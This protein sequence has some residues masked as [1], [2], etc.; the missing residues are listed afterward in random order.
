M[1]L[2]GKAFT[3]VSI[4][5]ENNYEF[6]EILGDATCNK[7]IVW[8]IQE[9]FPVL[10]NTAGV[11][12]IARLRIN[13]VSKKKFSVLAEKLGFGDF[14]SCEKEIKERRVLETDP[15]RCQKPRV[16]RA[17]L[18]RVSNGRR[19]QGVPAPGS[20]RASAQTGNRPATRGP[21]GAEQPSSRS[22]PPLQLG[23]DGLNAC[24]S[25]KRR[26]VILSSS[27]F[28]FFFF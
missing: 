16:C 19:A 1:A 26:Q 5:T 7:A 20:Y 6:F 3:H 2:Y 13:L 23:T 11:K 17:L 4:H 28:F 24:T 12:V 21:P 14:I 27:F 15:H 10:R 22:C 8:Y 25:C 18:H 9:R